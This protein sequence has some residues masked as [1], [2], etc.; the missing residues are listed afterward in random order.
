MPRWERRGIFLLGEA[1]PAVTPRIMRPVPPRGARGFCTINIRK[2]AGWEG[3]FTPAGADNIQP[4][5]ARHGGECSGNESAG[6]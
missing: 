3:R 2:F 5:I 6:D 4:Q 1:G